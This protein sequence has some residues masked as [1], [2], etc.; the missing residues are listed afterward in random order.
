MHGDTN[1]VKISDNGS[2]TPKTIKI[3]SSLGR[4]YVFVFQMG[5]GAKYYV[6]TYQ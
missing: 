4:R 3:F 6:K 2:V 1:I 5:Y